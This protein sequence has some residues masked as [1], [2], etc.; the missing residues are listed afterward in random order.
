MAQSLANMLGTSPDAHVLYV[1][2]VDD[3]DIQ[4]R[5][6]YGALLSSLFQRPTKVW[7]RQE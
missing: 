7:N 5:T 3:N 2:T 6:A 4:T 1:Q